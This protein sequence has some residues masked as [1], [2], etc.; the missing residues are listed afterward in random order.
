MA[1]L[2]RSTPGIAI[3]QHMP[4]KFT[5]SFAERLNAQ[6]D[7]EVRE[8]RGGERLLPAQPKIS[9]ADSRTTVATMT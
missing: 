9:S 3:V 1:K 7:M 8:A 6:S 4:P 2:P 5:A